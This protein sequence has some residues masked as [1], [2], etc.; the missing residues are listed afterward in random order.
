[1]VD[2]MLNE[3]WIDMLRVIP[4]EQQNQIVLVLKNQSEVAVDTLFRYE[5]NFMVLRGRVAGTTDESRAFFIPYDQ[6]VY[7]RL[8]RVVNLTEL[9]SIFDS[10]PERSSVAEAETS[11]PTPDQAPE[12][13]PPTVPNGTPVTDATATRNA[14]LDRIRAARATQSASGR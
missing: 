6:M 14:L 4:F 13:A 9:Q 11:P 3:E 12:A 8:E 7:Y 1:V 5:H 10:L 2:A